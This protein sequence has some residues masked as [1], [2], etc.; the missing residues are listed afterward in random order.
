MPLADDQNV[1]QAF[2]PHGADETFSECVGPRRPYR[3]LDHPRADVGGHAVERHSELR[4]AIPDHEPAPAGPPRSMTRLRAC[5][6]TH[7]P[8]GQRVMLRMWT[9]LLSTSITKKTY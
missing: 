7:G 3:R 8:L 2:T 4:V 6:A 1:I 5:C 9:R